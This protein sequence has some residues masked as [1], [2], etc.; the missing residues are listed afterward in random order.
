MHPS[1]IR[2]GQNKYSTLQLIEF[3]GS[4]KLKLNGDQWK[5]NEKSIS[6]ESILLDLTMVPF[7][8]DASDSDEWF[9]LDGTKRLNALYDF[10]NNQFELTDLEF[11]EKYNGF[12][13][14]KLPFKQRRKIEEAEFTVYAINQGVPNDVRLSILKRIVPEPDKIYWRYLKFLLN[15]QSSEIFEQMIHLLKKDVKL[16]MTK[17]NDYYELIANSIRF[18]LNSK[19]VKD[20]DFNMSYEDLILYFNQLD[21]K[22]DVLSY[23]KDSIKNLKEVNKSLKIKHLNKKTASLWISYLYDMNIEN[24]WNVVKKWNDSYDNIFR[25][26]FRNDYIKKSKE[27]KEKMRSLSEKKYDIKNKHK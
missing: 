8:L 11:F 6:I 3:I 15:K 4:G 13:F 10:M 25:K 12:T 14:E 16:N 1:D 19:Q 17:S 22:D 27:I 24:S 26:Y 5:G 23:W 21:N 18:Y 7:Y 20:F 9:I 2:I